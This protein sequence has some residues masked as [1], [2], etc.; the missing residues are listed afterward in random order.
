M[1]PIIIDVC[2]S[3]FLKHVKKMGKLYNLPI[4][5]PAGATP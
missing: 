1:D 4:L 2:W 3:Y 5:H